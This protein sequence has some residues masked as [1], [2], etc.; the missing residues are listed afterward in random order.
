MKKTEKQQRSQRQQ[1]Q[2]IQLRVHHK[3]DH[4]EDRYMNKSFVDRQEL[5]TKQRGI[6][7]Q[8]K[9]KNHVYY[10]DNNYSNQLQC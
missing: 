10:Y 1:Q 4:C 3:L 6:H 5:Y 9:D 2:Q 7:S 8:R